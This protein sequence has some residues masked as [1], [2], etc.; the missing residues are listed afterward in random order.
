M[1]KPNATAQ[2]ALE[3]ADSMLVDTHGDYSA[4]NAPRPFNTSAGKVA[5]QFRKFQLIQL[6]LMTKLI[7]NSFTGT[8][9]RAAGKAL[10][11]ILTHTAVMAGAIGLPGFAAISWL[12]SGLSGMLGD[13]DDEPL[14]LEQ[15]LREL[16]GSELATLLTRGLPAALGVD[17]SSKLGAGN[18]LSLLPF[19]DLDLSSRSG[20]ESV[21]FGL[22]GGPA[23]GL[24]L[25]A[26]DGIGLMRDGQYY[27]GLEQLVPTGATNAMKAYRM[28]DEG[29]TRRNGDVLIPS[30]EISGIE[31]FVQGFGLQPAQL[32]ERQF[33]GDIKFDTEARFKTRA[34]R[35]RGQYLRARKEQDADGLQESREAWSKL[36][37]ARSEAGFKRDPL[38]SLIRSGANQDKRERNTI[39]GVQFDRKSRRF[40]EELVE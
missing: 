38:S 30:E 15:Q 10:A 39:E 28:Q 5:L 34:E 33:R 13:D 22:M 14:N 21:G 6:T 12:L 3:Y 31:S 26:A 20:V 1:S 24:A 17:L 35:I 7:K 40:V 27:R 8:D 36:Q 9:R 32:S 37:D 29:M 23:G 25:R 4:S 19:N 18:M 11:F 2:S 16:A